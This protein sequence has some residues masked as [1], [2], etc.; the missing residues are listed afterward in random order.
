MSTKRKK[1][2]SAEDILLAQKESKKTEKY[3]T[4]KTSKRKTIQVRI[5]EKWHQR[6]KTIAGSEKIMI[7]FFLDRI[8]EHFFR[9]Y[10]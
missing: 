4:R 2:Y 7:S 9:N 3:F 10:E 5:G 8:C 6:I 1:L